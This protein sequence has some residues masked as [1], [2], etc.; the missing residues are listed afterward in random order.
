LTAQTH[1]SLAKLL[2]IEII[3][4]FG[5]KIAHHKTVRYNAAAVY[6]TKTR[7]LGRKQLENLARHLLFQNAETEAKSS[8]THK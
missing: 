7:R 3:Y 2:I 5:K 6:A 1:F 8:C 4:Y